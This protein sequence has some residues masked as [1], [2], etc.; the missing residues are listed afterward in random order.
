MGN[1]SN[2]LGDPQR[3]RPNRLVYL[4]P[5]YC[6]HKCVIVKSTLELK[7]LLV[8]LREGVLSQRLSQNKVAVGPLNFTNLLSGS[9]VIHREKDPE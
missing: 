3:N 7:V 1:P 9:R 6:L 5:V 4:C 8:H 2:R